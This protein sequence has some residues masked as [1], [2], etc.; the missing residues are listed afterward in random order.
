VSPGDVGRTALEFVNTLAFAYFLAIVAAY[1]AVTL[2]S[3]FEVRRYGRRLVHARLRRSL[4]SQLTPPITLCVPCY[5]ER[6]VILGSVRSLLS[7][8]YP[9][10]EVVLCND[11]STDDTLRTLIDGFALHRVDQIADE[12]I[13]TAPVRGVWR[14]RLHSNLTVVDK[15]NG[16]R[17]DALNAAINFSRAPLICCVDADSL[18]E[19][20]A[21]LSAVR[22]FVE[23]P[24]RTVATGGII[25][26]ANGCETARGHVV[27]VALPRT[28][29]PMLQTVEYLR[30][31]TAARTGWSAINGLLIISGAFG[32]F[33]KDLVVDAGGFA[34]DSIGEDF[35][36]CVRLHRRMRERR[37]PY[38][39]AFVPDPV[40]WTEAPERL[41]EL[42]GQR[43]R[44]H[45]GLTDTLLRHRRMILNP[46]YGV[47]GL[48][49]LP[50]FLA[51]ELLGAFIELAGLVTIGI[52]LA[53]GIVNTETAVLFYALA[54]LAGVFLS[55]S[56]LLLEDLAF[57]TFARWRDFL[58]LVAYSVAENFGY[59]QLM[60]GYRVRGFVKYLRGDHTW[61]EIARTGYAEEDL[62]IG[63][64]MR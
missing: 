19:P 27:S 15:E 42:G 46:R 28:R 57:R 12:R 56:A 22:P 1:G 18:L 2:L 41:G 3:W 49:A 44:W 38:H 43:D 54:I 6:E 53:L 58:R 47:V 51:F 64:G 11:G 26:V 25:R 17:S 32:L 29:L 37:R 21:L 7:L 60:V 30:A 23:R 40:C 39:I 55:L 9:D 48:L 4:R 35:E 31:F 52:S 20:G 50:F 10:H 34:T 8:S 5:N 63:V 14:S 24:E 59:R 45:R 61:G 62:P 13:P 33:R 16:G 36:L